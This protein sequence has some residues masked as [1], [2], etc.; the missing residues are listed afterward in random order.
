MWV[1]NSFSVTYLCVSTLKYVVIYNYGTFSC[2]FGAKLLRAT[3]AGKG[4]KQIFLLLIII[5]NRNSA[6]IKVSEPKST[7]GLVNAKISVTS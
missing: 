3:N 1:K 6:Q 4:I 7:S 2:V 5:I